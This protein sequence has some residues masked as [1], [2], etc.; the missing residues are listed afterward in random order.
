MDEQPDHGEDTYRGSGRL[1]RQEGGH[2]R[3]RL[4]HRPGR[5]AR[6][7]PRGRRRADHLPARRRRTTPRRPPRWC[8]RPAARRSRCRG[9]IREERTAATSSTGR[10]TRA[11]RHRHPGQQR[12]LPDVAGRR[13]R[14]HHHRAVR[15]GHQD[16]PLR[17]VLALQGGRAAHGAGRDD[18][19]HV[20]GP[21]L[22]TRRRTCST[23]PPPRPAIVN[24]T[25]GLAQQP[26]R[27]GHPGQ[28]ASR[29]ARSGPR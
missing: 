24:F 27:E 4:R 28:R 18:H 25:K 14:R 17:H 12:R 15:P 6:V 8:A 13:H 7:R 11:R 16:Q 23:T 10:S 2:H 26:G 20:V 22:P 5:R 29:P 3:R 1:E 19:Q 21:G 9:D